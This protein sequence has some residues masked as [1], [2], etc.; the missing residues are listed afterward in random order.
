MANNFYLTGSNNP[1]MSDEGGESI[2]QIIAEANALQ[3]K[4]VAMERQ[5]ESMQ[6]NVSTPVAKGTN[7]N[8]APAAKSLWAM[9][10]EEI[11]PLSDNQ[12]KL[13]YNDKEY[14]NNA[15]T[16]QAYMQEALH[17]LAMPIIEGTANGKAALEA[18]LNLVKTKKQAVIAES[19]KELENLEKFRI[20]SMANANL[21]YSDFLKAIEENK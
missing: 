4:K 9:I 14:A 13:L 15:E 6:K 17:S 20:A 16:L 21:T 5:L 3:A 2:E 11:A 18:Q 8:A 1:L 19:N 7:S 12:R 10:D